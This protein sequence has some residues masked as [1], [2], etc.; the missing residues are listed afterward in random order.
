[1]SAFLRRAKPVLAAVLL[2]GALGGCA[3][4]VPPPAPGYY[5]G[6]YYRAPYYGPTYGP[7]YAYGPWGPPRFR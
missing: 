7:G 4:Y 6:G 5:H 2:A 1:M 3:V